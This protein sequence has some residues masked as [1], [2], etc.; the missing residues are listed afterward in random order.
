MPVL[1]GAL[2]DVTDGEIKGCEKY[3][4]SFGLDE[5][6]MNAEAGLYFQF[7][8]KNGIPYN[9]P[10]L[11]DFNMETWTSQKM[12][13]DRVRRAL[14]MDCPLNTRRMPESDKPVSEIIQDYAADQAL[15]L[16]DFIGAFEKMMRYM[17]TSKIRNHHLIFVS[18]MATMMEI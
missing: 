2:D 9:C 6:L 13:D 15:W 7:E 12:K 4:F 18:G 10:G 14:D 3:R 11:E 8:E 16:T 5:M 17:R 1:R